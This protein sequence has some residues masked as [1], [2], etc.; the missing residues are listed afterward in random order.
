MDLPV[1]TACWPITIVAGVADV[2]PARLTVSRLA[3]GQLAGLL[4]ARLRASTGQKPGQRDR[5]GKIM[6][7][8]QAMLCIAYEDMKVYSLTNYQQW[9]LRH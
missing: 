4:P 6:P 8:L 7:P 3:Y 1:R 2:R 9:L 5:Q